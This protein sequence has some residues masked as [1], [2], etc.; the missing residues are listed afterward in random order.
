MSQRHWRLDDLQ[1]LI[2]YYLLLNT[3]QTE[4]RLEYLTAFSFWIMA[5]L[6]SSMTVRTMGASW[7][8]TC[9][10]IIQRNIKVGARSTHTM[11]EVTLS[12]GEVIGHGLVKS[13]AWINCVLVMFVEKVEKANLLLEKGLNVGEMFEEVK[14][15]RFTFMSESMGMTTRSL[16]PQQRQRVWGTGTH[17]QDVSAAS[18]H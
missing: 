4:V 17:H 7:T 1:Y 5:L 9:N 12:V 2:Y 14:S 10:L 13:M 18:R 3:D 15:W 6:F 16:S 8:W 11:E